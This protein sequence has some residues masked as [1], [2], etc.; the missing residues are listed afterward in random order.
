MFFVD[1]LV[2]TEWVDSDVRISSLVVGFLGTSC[3]MAA[4]D[5]MVGSW[6]TVCLCVNTDAAG[7]SEYSCVS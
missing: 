5:D 3:W 1:E 2:N 7:A 6:D 4:V